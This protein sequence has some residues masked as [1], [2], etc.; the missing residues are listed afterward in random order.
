MSNAIKKIDAMH[1]YYGCAE[2]KCEDCE[3]FITIRHDR[4]YHK[5][6]MYGVSSSEASDWRCSYPA[7]GL[8]NKPLPDE[9]RVMDRLVYCRN[10]AQPIEGQISS[11]SMEVA[12]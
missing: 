8:F 6:E 11:F 12:E 5:C 3:H 7:C 4:L 10:D 1:Y 9:R 2:G